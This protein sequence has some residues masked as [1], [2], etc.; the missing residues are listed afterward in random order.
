MFKKG[1]RE[2]PGD[3]RGIT[4]LSMIV[5]LHSRVINNCLLKYLELNNKLHEGQGSFSIG[6]FYVDSSVFL[7]ELNQSRIEEGK[8][9]YAF[10]LMLRKLLIQY[11]EIDYGIKYGKWVLRVRCGEW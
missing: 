6:K 9:T 3:F 1:D 10:F 5:K 2:D 7:N 4:L 8:L 11:G